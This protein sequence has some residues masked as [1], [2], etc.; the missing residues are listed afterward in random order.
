M[1]YLYYF[2]CAAIIGFLIL[3]ALVVVP[4]SFSAS[5]YLQ[6]PPQELS[7]RWYHDFFSSNTWSPSMWLSI[8]VSILTM[9]VTVILG[10]ASAFAIT[11]TG[12]RGGSALRA[13]LL[14]PMI[15]PHIAIAISV[16]GWFSKMG[17]IGS[18]WGLVAVYT[19]FA[20][21]FAL[22]TI[23]AA[24]EGFDRSLERAALNL[25]ATKF[26]AFRLVILPS[27]AP[28]LLVA[29]LFS[30]VTAFDELVVAMFI[31]GT[32]AT[33][34]PK[35]MWD[36]LHSEINPTI[37]VAATVLLAISLTLFAVAQGFMGRSGASKTL[38]AGKTK[39][40]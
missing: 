1:R 3:P 18:S 6:F 25:G 33:T 28:G 24:L 27:I 16:Y 19:G 23:G 9:F 29:A 2:V 7:L 13:L 34:L 11:M 37:A 21:P 38:G 12:I 10:T 31:S 35:R 40:D 4:I 26:Q 8:K 39:A 32:T 17:L 20:L 15:V 30:F 36:G 22:V 5:S 14:L